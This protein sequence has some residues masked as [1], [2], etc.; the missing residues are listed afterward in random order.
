MM[1]RENLIKNNGKIIVQK[2]ALSTTGT[3]SIPV[4][5]LPES[6]LEYVTVNHQ[7]YMVKGA[8]YDPLCNGENAVDVSVV[9]DGQPGYSL[10]F[11]LDGK[12][13]QL[14]EDMEL[15]SAP[16]TI[17]KELRANY[18]SYQV[19]PQIEKLTLANSQTQYL[20][21]LTKNGTS[22]EVIFDLDGKVVCEN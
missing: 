21:D 6:V 13:V 20:I 18:A 4:E 17:K 3:G 12:F 9:K 15:V 2:T 19:A 5:Q 10:I 16:E 14:E 7:G 8:A 1:R 22:K 11:T